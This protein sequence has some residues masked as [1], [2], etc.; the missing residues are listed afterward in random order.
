MW[1]LICL[2]GAGVIPNLIKWLPIAIAV[3]A[4]LGLSW[5]LHSLDV[6]RRE[7]NHLLALEQKEIE[8]KQKC[9]EDKK[10]TEE[11]SHGYQQDIA[12]LNAQLAKRLRQ[13]TR[14]IVPAT[15]K[16]AGLNA[17]PTS[18]ELSGQDGVDA[19]SYIAYAG[20][21][22]Q[23]RLQLIGLQKFVNLVWDKP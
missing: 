7:K 3:S 21:C 17:T 12:N 5:M 4:T 23:V 8:I 22:E 10:L 2:N 16:A 9:A 15:G 18:N 13:P 20:E 14:C 11:V 6:N 19:L 1:L